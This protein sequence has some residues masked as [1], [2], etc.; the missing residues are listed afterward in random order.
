[1]IA[2]DVMADAPRLDVRLPGLED[3]SP[4][5]WL[6]TRGEAP[7]GWRALAAALERFHGEWR[8]LGPLEHSVEHAARRL[9]LDA[10]RLAD[11]LMEPFRPAVDLEVRA[12]A[13]AGATSMSPPTTRRMVSCGVNLRP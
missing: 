13:E 9:I 3:R 4:D 6:L 2:P 1:M 7:E 11:D 8:R 5:R 10:L 12:I